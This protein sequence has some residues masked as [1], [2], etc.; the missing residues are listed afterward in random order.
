MTTSE[1]REGDRDEDGPNGNRRAP[2]GLFDRSRNVSQWAD[3]TNQTLRSS[4]S[5]VRQ[6][7]VRL[8]RI[9][10]DIDVETIAAVSMF[11]FVLATLLV[12][13]SAVVDVDALKTF[14][15]TGDL[16]VGLKADNDGDGSLLGT[17][18]IFLA[19]SDSTPGI[20]N[21]GRI[22]FIVVIG[23]VVHRVNMQFIEQTAWTERF[24]STTWIPLVGITLFV[25][26]LLLSFTSVHRTVWVLTT[27][28]FI[29]VYYAS[30]FVF[31][32]LLRTL[33][34]ARTWLGSS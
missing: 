25:A 22:A 14:V 28:L 20:T 11:V 21:L 6:R 33:I 31:L 26:S 24:D 23:Q 4:Y 10:D 5:F 2:F 19:R 7:W 29:L 13:I 15:E 3:S 30:A 34:Q 8:D 18:G 9:V 12:S 17:I 1:G 16:W 27:Q 32:F